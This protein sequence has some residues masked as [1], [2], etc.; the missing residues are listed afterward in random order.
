MWSL[1]RLSSLDLTIHK[2]FATRADLYRTV[3][4]HPK[5][6]VDAISAAFENFQRKTYGIKAQEHSTPEK[7]KKRHHDSCIM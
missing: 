4:T 7:K 1:L 3:Y 2:L 6:K 5:V